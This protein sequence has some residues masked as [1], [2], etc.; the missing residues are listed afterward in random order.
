MTYLEIVEFFLVCAPDCIVEAVVV[1]HKADSL[2]CVVFVAVANFVE[3][4]A[5]V[6]VNSLRNSLDFSKV[7]LN[8]LENV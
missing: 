7:S 6:A 5:G 8:I 1:R 2:V 4:I 3:L